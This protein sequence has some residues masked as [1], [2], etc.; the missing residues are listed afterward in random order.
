[1]DLSIDQLRHYLKVILLQLAAKSDTPAMELQDIL[2][3]VLAE[4]DSEVKTALRAKRHLKII[5]APE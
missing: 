2:H 1:M 5:G 3:E 4:L